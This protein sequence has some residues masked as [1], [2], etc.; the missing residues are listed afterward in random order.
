MTELKNTC[1]K[2]PGRLCVKNTSKFYNDSIGCQFKA[3]ESLRL[4]MGNP[5]MGSMANV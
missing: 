5:V 3:A 1:R 2:P 4:H